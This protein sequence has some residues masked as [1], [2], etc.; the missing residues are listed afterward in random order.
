MAEDNQ[1]VYLDHAASTPVRPEVVAGMD[2][3]LVQAAMAAKP[4]IAN[5]NPLGS[6]KITCVT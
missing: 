2:R 4:M 1:R 5:N 6:G 3:L